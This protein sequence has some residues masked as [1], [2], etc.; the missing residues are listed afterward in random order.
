MAEMENTCSL[1]RCMQ[2]VPDLR[3]PYNQRHKFLDIIII[4][5]TARHPLRNGYLERVRTGHV[6]KKNGWGLLKLRSEKLREEGREEGRTLE[7]FLWFRMGI[8]PRN[9]RQRGWELPYQF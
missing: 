2:E 5:V 8:R 9:V 6:P 3:A 7:I 4:A 1:V